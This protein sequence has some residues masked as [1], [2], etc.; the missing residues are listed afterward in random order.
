MASN[1]F[2]YAE[3]FNP[4]NR[5]SGEAREVRAIDPVAAEIE[6]MRRQELQDTFEQ[7]PS[8]DRA[9]RVTR[10]ARQADVP[11]VYVEDDL[12]ATERALEVRSF[13]NL[14]DRYPAIG[15][16]ATRNPRAAAAAQDDHESLGLLGNAWEGWKNL[17][18]RLAAGT[19]GALGG[20][21][22]SASVTPP[23]LLGLPELLSGLGVP[24][25]QAQAT[26]ALAAPIRR[27]AASIREKGRAENWWA[28]TALSGVEFV[29]VTAA[30]AFTRN[31]ALATAIPAVAVR[32]QALGDARDQGMPEGRA[33]TYATLQGGIEYVTERIP[34]GFLVDAIVKRTPFA[35]TFVRQLAT[36]IPGEQIATA[37]QDFVDWAMLPENE[38]KTFQDYLD[39]RPG[40]AL[41]TLVATGSGVT[42]TTAGAKAVQHTLDAAGRVAERVGQAQQARREQRF[43]RDMEGALGVSK[44][45]GRDTE[46][47][48]D[49][50]REQAADAGTTSIYVPGD[51]V[52]TY[53]QSD[54]YDERSDPFAELN[55]E[56]AANS[57]GDVVIPIER[58]LTDVVGSPAWNAVKDD[59]R[60]TPGGMSAR[61][62][63]TFEAAMEDVMADLSDEAARQDAAEAG[64]RSVRD[65]IV[66]RVAEMF[67]VSF[68]SPTARTIAELFAQRVQTRASRLG[69]E[70]T[71]DELD[72][73]EVRQVMPEGVAEAA[74]P[75]QT[76]PVFAEVQ[77]PKAKAAQRQLRRETYEAMPPS[78]LVDLD[79]AEQAEL[80]NGDTI[81]LLTAD[82]E[83]VTLRQTSA[84]EYTLETPSQ[85]SVLP[86]GEIESILARM[87]AKRVRPDAAN[88]EDAGS[89]AATGA[90]DI[91]PLG[92]NENSWIIVNRETGEAVLE[93][94]QESV[95]RKVNQ[96]KYEVLTA[97]Q[98]LRR[99]N[100]KPE[101]PVKPEAR[102]AK[103]T[104]KQSDLSD[105]TRG[106]VTFDQSR[107]IIELFQSRTLA[108]PLHELSHMWLEELRFDASLPLAPNQRKEDWEQLKTDWDTVTRWFSANGHPI[109]SDGQI[110]ADAHELFARTGERY[111]MEGKAPTSALVRLFES[112]RAWLVNIY[113]TVDRLR[114]PITPEIREVFDR[115]LATD[116]EIAAV[117]ERQGLAALFKDAASVGMS[118]TEFA[119]YQRQVDDAR[120]GAHASLLD[121]TMKAI[122]RR[123]TERY[124]EARKT[125][126]A[127]EQERIDASP[128]FKALATMKEQRVSKE[129]IV[130]SYGAE[131]LD[132]LPVR[133][134]PLYVAGGTHPD[135]IAEQSGYPSGG[136]MIEALIGAEA[137]H[138]A[139]KAGGDP[140]SMRE[141]AIETATDEEM[142]RR[143]GDPLN[144]GSIEREA[145]GAVHS[146]MQGEVIASELRVL[147]R[148]TGQRPT[149][150]RIAREWARGKIRGGT[151]QQEA[152]PSAIQRY[153]RNAAKAGREAEQAMLKQDVNEA[154][155][156]KQF[157]ML[158]NA[159]V[160]E[161]KEAHDEV[162]A[163]VKRMDKIARAKTRKSVAQDYLEQAHALMEAVDL[164][165]RTQKSQ[166]MQGRWEAF[167][168]AREAEGY[169]VVVPASF[170]ATI[171]KTNWSRLS[172]ENLLAL[173]EAVKQVMH[174]GRLQ[175][176]LEDDAELREWEAIFAE[177]VDGAG[178][179]KGPPPQSLDDPGFWDGV[180]ARI[181]GGDAALLKLET[182]FDWL[183]GGN[184]NGVFNRVAFRPV[185]DAQAREQDLLKDYHGRVKALFEAL[186][187]EVVDRWSDKVTLPFVDERTGRNPTKSRQAVIAMALNTGNAGN[188]Q[189]L[190]DGY[191]WDEGA[192]EA[193][194]ADTL[195][196]EEWQFVQ[197]VWDTIDTLWP[198]IEAMERRVNGI[199]PAK[200]EARSF[201][202]PFGTMR[203]GYYPAIYDSRLDLK[204]EERRGK[205]TDL[206]ES[207]YTRAT[208]RASATKERADKARRPVLL[209]LGVINRHLG[210]VIHDITHREAVMQAHRF[211]T[212]A[213]VAS[214]VD[215]ALGQEIRK[216][217]RPWVKFVANSWAM[218]RAGNEG[219]GAWIGKMRA[220]AT[221]VGLGLRG[222][223]MVT[224]LAGYS[225]STEIVGEKWMAQAIAQATA[226]PIESFRFVAERSG[227]VRHRM[228]TLDRD[229]RTELARLAAR[230]PV[231]KA[232]AHL[233]EAKVFMFHGIGLMDRVVVVPTWI[234][235]YN[236]ALAEGMTEADA[237][238]SADKAV[239]QSQGAGAP[240]DLAAIQRGTGQ[241]GQALKLFTMF[242]GYFSAYYQRQRTLVR[243]VRG[244]DNRR[245]RNMPRLAAR[246]FWLVIVPPLLTE[247]LKAP[248]G[249]GGPDDDEAWLQWLSRKL[250]ANQLG[251]I[252]L[253]RDVFEPAWN[254][255]IKGRFYNPSISP[256]QRALE[257]VTKTAGDAGQI[258]RGEETRHATKDTLELAG[259][260]TGLV[261]GQVAA[262]TQF[263]VD[264]GAGDADPQSFGDW[265]EGLSRGKLEEAD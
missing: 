79:E 204:T 24:D 242:Y 184:P 155:R 177:A 176:T 169:D 255:A 86:A 145:L 233:D 89:T 125:V 228:D 180:K 20:L 70:L 193:Y 171:G 146:E 222:T 162:T 247:L 132:L 181:A 5:P 175:Q 151:V 85:V 13:T 150:Y 149:P 115:L 109:G 173:D 84:T 231:S 195:T 67:G 262:A 183:D 216:A 194:L 174:L 227:E 254:K 112:F 63:E 68:T 203:G 54:S 157:Q 69:Q 218:E 71:G 28:E 88:V 260:A 41:G 261:P 167:A 236:K 161:A 249:A 141:R 187:A 130:D 143:W 64:Q 154:F 259:Y 81:H 65:K 127:E 12:E 147:S 82:G 55:V 62:A 56:E 105:G 142:N 21:V 179:I 95:A 229:I 200:V 197:G 246:A 160:A 209:D 72:G 251:P 99:I 252:P 35:K 134:P 58:F 140:R 158:N 243:D 90:R 138:R 33:Q 212:N 100:G 213:R 39:A 6:R 121:K 244:V 265:L 170:E 237:A 110:P 205:E 257:S 32:G 139:Q 52:R 30:A 93:T 7:L 128:V 83:L 3:R 22:E 123:E 2:D 223:T 224:Q 129:W 97:G 122:R 166:A 235:A 190:A 76:S 108:T 219:F 225:N 241:W 202:T 156:Q 196:E 45:K 144:D 50:L 36:E 11:E 47:L 210:E 31:P 44:L 221:A 152:S 40:A 135:A 102:G 217:F 23:I 78:L 10:A 164:K 117:R 114:A 264:V 8:P 232:A 214:A 234:G 206:F 75:A 17:N 148:K 168:A 159:L 92:D 15:R 136:A 120:A 126:R 215:L 172:V 77:G 185:A 73:L 87:S 37:T 57:G 46:A 38:S 103:R 220:N 199:A 163:A 94:S 9:A 48:R 198:E 61:E 49:L 153:A 25:Y 59:V 119:A 239:R 113:R 248:L 208:T 250:L 118:E 1:P 124:R 178:N 14:A 74:E 98:H 189:R 116:E 101:T 53:Q 111:A 182:V 29:P 201:A 106:Q 18:M 51:A 27:A 240:K 207:G 104:L 256:I 107:R 19:V 131:A 16:F 253:A 43:L 91:P 165:A 191:G 238:Y 133:V 96:A 137:A 42:A 230:N 26:H 80:R 258:A 263:L 186:P 60:L 211:L 192:I 34:A 66:D 188:L 226:H 245:P 4:R